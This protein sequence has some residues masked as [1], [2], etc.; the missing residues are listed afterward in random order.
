MYA[1]WFGAAGGMG[2]GSSGALPSE[3]TPA[4]Q[5]NPIK[6]IRNPPLLILA[7]GGGLSRIFFLRELPPPLG[8][9]QLTGCAVC[10]NR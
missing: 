10:T 1:I 2:L 7:W 3:N 5:K 9:V 8:A 4:L 6:P